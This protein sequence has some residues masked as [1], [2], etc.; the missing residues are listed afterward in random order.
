MRKILSIFAILAVSLG[1]SAPAFAQIELS[2]YGG[3]Q[4]SP[5][6]RVSGTYPG[7]GANFN[8]LIGWEGKSLAPPPYYGVRA[9]WWRRSDLGFGVELT[10]AKVYAPVAERVAIG[11]D[12]LE[13]TD[14]HNILT[15]NVTKRWNDRFGSF[16][17]YVGAGLGIAMPHVDVTSANGHRT[18]GYQVTGPAARLAAGMKYDLSDRWALFG[19]YQFTYSSNT[20]KLV[21]GGTL[22]TDIITNAIN[23]GVSFSF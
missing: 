17:P 23:V 2:F 4:S 9:T 6:S 14:G 20:A 16:T 1:V 7:T 19:E 3:S 18:F 15:F 13:F 5:H 22:N 12:S 11:F 8:A 10:H 21:G